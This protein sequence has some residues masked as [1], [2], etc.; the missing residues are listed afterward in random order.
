M[1]YE[2]C[3]SVL[4]IY[5][6]GR[7]E[8]ILSFPKDGHSDAFRFR[9]ALQEKL[10][11][12][13]V[14]KPILGIYPIHLSRKPT[15]DTSKASFVEAWAKRRDDVTLKVWG[16]CFQTMA[17]DHKKEGEFVEIDL[18]VEHYYNIVVSQEEADLFFAKN[19]RFAKRGCSKECI[20]KISGETGIGNHS[21]FVHGAYEGS[22]V[23]GI[24]CAPPFRLSRRWECV[25]LLDDM[26]EIARC[27][28]R[29]RALP[30]GELAEEEDWEDR[31]GA[32]FIYGLA[33]RGASYPEMEAA[34]QN[35][36]RIAEWTSWLP[37]N[38]VQKTLEREKRNRLLESAKSIAPR[39][40]ATRA[41]LDL[42]DE[43]HTDDKRAALYAMTRAFSGL[44]PKQAPGLVGVRARRM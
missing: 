27:S 21:H 23:D 3:E 29:D 37:D 33:N 16:A 42:L 26:T 18:S 6:G 25:S 19:Q 15:N 10:S 31:W 34:F 32:R 5:R 28:C 38:E 14:N 13:G 2:D 8:P 35:T 22:R 30:E 9:E 4:K 1:R 43:D 17:R 39:K 40:T 36:P 12:F 11:V 7:A 20:K 44:L 24:D 41:L